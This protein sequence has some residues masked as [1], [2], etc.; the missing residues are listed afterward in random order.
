MTFWM[1]IYFGMH[2][3]GME[4]TRSRMCYAHVCDHVWW[5]LA[6][7]AG[8]PAAIW[9]GGVFSGMSTN[10]YVKS[11][12][13]IVVTGCHGIRLESQGVASRQA[14]LDL[15]PVDTI[16]LLWLRTSELIMK[17]DIRKRA[18]SEGSIGT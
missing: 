3:S 2:R 11:L 5:K 18:F 17:H 7:L 1:C 9:S 16:P 4:F 14:A 15:R 12:E 8:L 10:I 13:S 6:A